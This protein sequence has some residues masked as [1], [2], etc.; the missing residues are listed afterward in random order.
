MLGPRAGWD[1]LSRGAGELHVQTA[2]FAAA[3]RERTGKQSLAPHSTRSGALPDALLQ[4][5][6]WLM[7]G[8]HTHR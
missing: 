8:L 4:W 1:L 7:L 6:R 2:M 5:R 3:T